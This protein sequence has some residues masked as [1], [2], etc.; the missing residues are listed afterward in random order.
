MWTENI[1]KTELFENNHAISQVFLE[2][3]YK[4]TSDDCVLNSSGVVWTK[5]FDA[6]SESKLRF[7]KFLRRSV[8]GALKYI[9][10][11]DYSMAI[12][13][14]SKSGSLEWKYGS[15]LRLSNN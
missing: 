1:L 2:H 15:F 12:D 8:N 6:F 9:W 4:M 11:F 7:P 5:T 14:F 10:K 13:I 3:K